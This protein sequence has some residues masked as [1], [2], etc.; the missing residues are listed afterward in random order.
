IFMGLTAWALRSH[1]RFPGG[2]IAA[3]AVLLALYLTHIGLKRQTLL[4][5]TSLFTFMTYKL[6]HRFKS[7]SWKVNFYASTLTRGVA[8]SF[9]VGTLTFLTAATVK[10][11]PYLRFLA[12]YGIMG[13]NPGAN[14][15]GVNEYI[16]MHTPT[17][18]VIFAMSMRDYPWRAEQLAY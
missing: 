9:F 8:V 13:D 7:K 11:L 18:A 12:Q 4:G 14:W 15:V 1:S 10:R 16:R 5:T 17:K 2:W 6:Y 3:S